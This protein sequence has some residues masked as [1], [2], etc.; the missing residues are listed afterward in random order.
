S[1]HAPG[2]APGWIRDINSQTLIR[3]RVL[4]AGSADALAGTIVSLS[5]V[6]DE[7]GGHGY[8]VL[9]NV[10]VASRPGGTNFW[11]CAADNAATIPGAAPSPAAD[12]LSVN[13]FSSADLLTLDELWPTMSEEFQVIAS[14]TDAV[15]A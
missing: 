1:A 11:T 7:R 9:D 5:I 3:S 14:S 15:A 10:K 8:T 6:Y 2:S 4:L 13:P 12:D